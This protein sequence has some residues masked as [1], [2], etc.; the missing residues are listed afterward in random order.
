[1]YGLGSHRD[2]VAMESRGLSH[3]LEKGPGGGGGGG[4]GGEME[5]VTGGSGE[6][7]YS[8]K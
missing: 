2:L 8:I 6:H 4:G 7:M 1:M 5:N 3:V